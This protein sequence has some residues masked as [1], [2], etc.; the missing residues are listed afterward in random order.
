MFAT[1]V[2]RTKRSRLPD[3]RSLAK[4]QN[5]QI[6]L[7]GCNYNPETVVGAHIRRANIAGMGQKPCDL[8][9]LYACSNCHDVIDGRVKSALTRLELDQFILFG[10]L[11]TLSIV[12]AELS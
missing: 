5:C 11:R 9:M 6:H 2:P 3:L 4:G 10:L 12:Y 8:A 7:P 1:A